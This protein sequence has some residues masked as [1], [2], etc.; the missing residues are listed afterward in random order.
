MK[1]VRFY[2]QTV[3]NIQRKSLGTPDCKYMESMLIDFIW[4]NVQVKYLTQ[5]ILY[6]FKIIYGSMKV[7]QMPPVHAANL[8]ASSGNTAYGVD[9]IDSELQLRR[10]RPKQ[11]WSAQSYHCPGNCEPTCANVRPRDLTI[12]GIN[13]PNYSSSSNLDILFGIPEKSFRMR[14]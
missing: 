13:V 12:L 7:T 3:I 9:V 8:V 2:V 14:I 10:Q 11:K 6:H 5:T 1:T 4:L